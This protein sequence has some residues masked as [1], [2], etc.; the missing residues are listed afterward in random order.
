M[1]NFFKSLF[2]SKKKKTIDKETQAKA[3]EK[4]FEVLKYAGIKANQMGK[5]AYASKCFC[6]AL[7]L[8]EDYEIMALLA[9]VYSAREEFDEALDVVNR[10]VALRPDDITGRMSRANL[11]FIMEREEDVIAACDEMITRDEKQFAAY[12]LRARSKKNLARLEACLEDLNLALGVKENFAE[13]FLLRAEVYHTLQKDTEALADIEKCVT[14]TPGEEAVFLWRGKIKE[15]LKDQE[16]AEESYQQVLDLNPFNEEGILLLGKLMLTAGKI[17]QAIGHF[18]DAIEMQPD[19][20]DAYRERALAKEML[21]DTVAA[22]ADRTK[23]EE[24]QIS[25][26]TEDPSKPETNFDH[27]YKDGIF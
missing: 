1:G 20:A 24:I 22:E 10:M 18:D 6:E 19:M 11:L 9:S 21:G 27:L 13:A 4:N 12:Y 16:G 17:E 15:T 25:K 2:S 3:G 7:N 8:K 23:A 26:E 5:T 14:L